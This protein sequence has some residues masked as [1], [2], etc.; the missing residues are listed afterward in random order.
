MIFQLH[1]CE[2][3]WEESV[4][5]I[6]TF[7]GQT[8]RDGDVE[9]FIVN[10]PKTETA[11]A[12]SDSDSNVTAVLGVPPATDPRNAVKVSIVAAGKKGKARN[13]GADSHIHPHFRVPDLFPT[14]FRGK[15]P[16]PPALQ[17]HPHFKPVSWMDRHWL[18]CRAVLGHLGR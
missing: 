12:W 14:V 4:P 2:S 7:N 16:P 6:E 5:V 18:D 17:S 13:G 11:Y 1:G 10:D 3:T 15:V 9:V 8:V